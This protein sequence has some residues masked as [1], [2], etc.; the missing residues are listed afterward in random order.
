MKN[1]KIK[2]RAWDCLV[3]Q[4]FIPSMINQD[5]DVR[6]TGVAL[7]ESNWRRKGDKFETWLLNNT[8]SFQLMQFT[9]LL[10]KNG[11]EIYEGDIILTHWRTVPKN[12]KVYCSEDQSWSIESVDEDKNLQ[13]LYDYHFECVVIGNIYE[14]ADLITK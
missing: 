4:M 9:G 6:H 2:F 1:R 12:Y 8:D 11:K 10:D 7:T 14:N 3:N 5:G 13:G